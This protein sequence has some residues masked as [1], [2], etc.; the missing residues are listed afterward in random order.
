MKYVNVISSKDYDEYKIQVNK[1]EKI[2]KKYPKLEW[3]KAAEQ[4]EERG[5]HAILLKRF[6]TDDF[7][8]LET[9]SDKKG[10]I[11]LK[12]KGLVV[13]PWEIIAE[14]NG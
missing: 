4:S 9:L 10:W 3:E 2:Y 8:F 5:Y 6:V 1:A 13:G 12:N 7:N 11:V 14:I